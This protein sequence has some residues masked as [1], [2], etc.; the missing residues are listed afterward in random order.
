MVTFL[1]SGVLKTFDND[2]VDDSFVKTST[3]MCEK[4]TR[5]RLVAYSVLHDEAEVSLNDMSLAKTCWV[6]CVLRTHT[7]ERQADARGNECVRRGCRNA[8]EGQTGTYGSQEVTREE[9]GQEG[10]SQDRGPRTRRCC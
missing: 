3:A 9:H 2:C 6:A 1:V 5:H 10:V 4:S 7:R 8:K